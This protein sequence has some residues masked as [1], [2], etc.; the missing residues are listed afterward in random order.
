MNSV[1]RVFYVENDKDLVES[2]QEV[3]NDYPNIELTITY[4][5]EGAKQIIKDEEPFDGYI[6]DIMLPRAEKDLAALEE[7]ERERTNL[8]DELIS[9]TDFE[10]ESLSLEILKLRRQIDEVD[11]EIEVLLNMEGGLELVELIA[12]K[13]SIEKLEVPVIFFTA[14]AAPELKDKCKEFVHDKFFYW[15][16]KPEDEEVVAKTL[17]KLLGLEVLAESDEGSK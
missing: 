2:F 16:E 13:H 17:S 7:K 1:K 5:M 10:S 6:I 12:K 11:A 4:Q 15:F 14:R 8:L 3:I 9:K